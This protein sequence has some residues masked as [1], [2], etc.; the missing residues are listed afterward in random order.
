MR[1]DEAMRWRSRRNMSE[2]RVRLAGQHKRSPSGRSSGIAQ[3]L[4]ADDDQGGGEA[5]PS[6]KRVAADIRGPIQTGS[7]GKGQHQQWKPKAA[8]IRAR[9]GVRARRSDRLVL[10]R[11]GIALPS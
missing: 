6:G 3:G 5:A 8:A 7:S 9:P 10:V 1:V 11:E 2:T 4:A